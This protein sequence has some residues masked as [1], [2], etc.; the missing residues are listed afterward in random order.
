MQVMIELWALQQVQ[1][2]ALEDGWPQ[3]AWRQTLKPW[4]A[5]RLVLLLRRQLVQ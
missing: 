1:E 5:E 2:R 4:L 3:R